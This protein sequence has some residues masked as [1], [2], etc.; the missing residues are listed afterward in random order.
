MGITSESVIAV[1]ARWF[2]NREIHI[3]HAGTGVE[4]PVF[5]LLVDE[6]PFWVHLGEGPGFIVPLMV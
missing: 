3:C 6:E 2:P 5:R 1:V 4:M